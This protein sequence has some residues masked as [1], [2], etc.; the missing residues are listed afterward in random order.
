[1]IGTANPETRRLSSALFG[2]E[3]TV[4]VALFLADSKGIVTAQDVTVP[5]GI[6]HSLVR[7]TLVRL[8][9]GG[10]VRAHPKTGGSRGT[11]YYEPVQ[12]ELWEAY[13][14][15]ARSVAAATVEHH[16]GAEG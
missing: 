11:Q 1:M 9:N 14:A 2:N 6:A 15:A 8:V 5:T 7:D 10:V 4:E 13:V 3:K 16:E 12:G